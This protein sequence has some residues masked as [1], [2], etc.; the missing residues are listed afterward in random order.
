MVPYPSCHVLKRYGKRQDIAVILGPPDSGAFQG[1]AT[2][3][4]PANGVDFGRRD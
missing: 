3:H 4:L 2:K 1:C